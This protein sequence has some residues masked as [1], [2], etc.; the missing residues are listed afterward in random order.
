VSA[1][2]PSRRS[3]RGWGWHQLDPRWADRLVA[4]SGVGQG[5]LVVDVGAGYGAITA[6]LVA[7]GAA[8]VAV[9]RH[10]QRLAVL[11]ARFGGDITLVVADA[12]DLRL[13]RRPFHVVANPPFA[14][15]SALLRRLL[16][17]GSR[18]V[19]AHLVLDERAIVRWAGAG[20]PAAARW[21]RQ[22]AVTVGERLPRAAFDPPPA[23][24]C[25]ILHLQHR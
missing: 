17:P 2:R 13:P 3:G 7:T 5:D 6:S 22:F 24:R 1:R 8:V 10:P 14:A 21:Q 23:V 12:A 9:E 18:L 11:R 25:R 16:H 4:S 19:A 15:T 20:A